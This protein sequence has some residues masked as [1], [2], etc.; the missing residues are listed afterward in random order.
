MWRFKK[1]MIRVFFILLSA[2]ILINVL[3]RLLGI[4]VRAKS[5]CDLLV[6]VPGYALVW[7]LIYPLWQEVRPAKGQRITAKA[8]VIGAV[9]VLFPLALIGEVMQ[10]IL[11]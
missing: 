5:P 2:A 11:A 8:A 1:V 10:F 3:H 7:F 4:D 6:Q 9:L